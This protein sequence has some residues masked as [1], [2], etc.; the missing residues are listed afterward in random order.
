MDKIVLLT[1]IL[2]LLAYVLYKVLKK[3][4]HKDKIGFFTNIILILTMGLFIYYLSNPTPIFRYSIDKIG[5]ILI[6]LSLFMLCFSYGLIKNNNTIFKK[7]VNIY[8]ILYLI[9]LVGITFFIGRS[10]NGFD[11][12][13]LEKIYDGSLIPFNTITAY[14]TKG[15][16]R[17]IL[18]NLV[19]NFIMLIPLS[20]LLMIKDKK[21]NNILK[22]L[23]IIIPIV[24]L[25]EVIQEVTWSGSFEVDDIILNL[26]GVIVFTFIIT[27][28]DII[29]KI[30][31][32]FYKSFNNKIIKYFLYII[33]IIIPILFIISAFYKIVKYMF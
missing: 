4:I 13:R 6:I 16:I 14:L 20:F 29:N 17:S 26:S 10:S 27:R 1:L 28:F 5:A 21:Y 19:G 30:R 33:S 32:V 25:I 8:I 22:Q 12:K 9:L 18:F 24:L 15:S 11:I 23:L 7:N 3:E 2:V 31:N